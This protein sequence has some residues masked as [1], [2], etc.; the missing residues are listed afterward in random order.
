M[1]R[2]TQTLEEMIQAISILMA[3]HATTV[4]K[5]SHW[6]LFKTSTT[7]AQFEKSICEAAINCR[8]NAAWLG[9]HME[10]KTTPQHGAYI[11]SNCLNGWLHQQLQNA[12]IGYYVWTI[13][14]DIKLAAFF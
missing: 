5:T 4:S 13:A 12:R 1:T 9:L 3:E 8:N 6:Y 14:G 2:R 11:L 10:Y 7:P